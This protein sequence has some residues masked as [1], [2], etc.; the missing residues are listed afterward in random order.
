MV[1][2]PLIRPAISGG[3]TLGGGRWTSHE[4]RRGGQADWHHL[5]SHRRTGRAQCGRQ[6]GVPAVREPP[7][8]VVAWDYAT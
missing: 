3:G 4:S 1:N 5:P 6:R 8:E 7:V 2:K